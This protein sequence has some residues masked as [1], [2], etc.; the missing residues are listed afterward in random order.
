MVDPE[1]SIEPVPVV[2]PAVLSL[3]S[4]GETAEALLKQGALGEGGDEQRERERERIGLKNKQ[5]MTNIGDVYCHKH[6]WKIDH[7]WS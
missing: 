2:M 3:T 5:H 7:R 1:S 6:F 4:L